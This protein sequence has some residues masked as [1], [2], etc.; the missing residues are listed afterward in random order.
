MVTNYIGL[1]IDY[2]GE[3]GK[4]LKFAREIEEFVMRVHKFSETMS[5]VEN[6]G[7]SG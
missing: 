6:R 1:R 7:W 3:D 5:I 4:S 2:K